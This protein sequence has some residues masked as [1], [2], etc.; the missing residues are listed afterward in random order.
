M[1]LVFVKLKINSPKRTTRVK[2][3]KISI[4]ESSTFSFF[5]S[6]IFS[7]KK[8]FLTLSETIDLF[9]KLSSDD[10]EEILLDEC[11]N[12]CTDIIIIPPKIEVLT[13]E[14]DINGEN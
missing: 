3:Y 4:T 5:I 7:S 8:T 13:V 10:D 9:N 11:R 14:E 12:Y 6:G 1:P 2:Q